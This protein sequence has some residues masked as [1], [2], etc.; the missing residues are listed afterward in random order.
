MEGF[1]FLH[2][3]TGFRVCLEKGEMGYI[4]ASCPELKG[5]HTQGGTVEEA[6]ANID[7]AIQTILEVLAE[8]SFSPKN[9]AINI[10]SAL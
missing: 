4:I 1:Y 3:P 5:C 8:E 2:E 9:L 10:A 6:L 7:D